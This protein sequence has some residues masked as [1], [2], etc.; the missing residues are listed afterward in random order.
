[1]K[2]FGPSPSLSLHLNFSMTNSMEIS[3]PNPQTYKN[4]IH[5]LLSHVLKYRVILQNRVVENREQ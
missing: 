4:E 2:V 3:H 5:I 1:M